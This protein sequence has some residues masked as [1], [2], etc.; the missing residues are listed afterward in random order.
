M[1]V[2]QFVLPPSKT[3]VP[4][5]ARFGAAGICN[6]D[7]VYVSTDMHAAT[8]F[9]CMHPSDNGRVYEV[10]PIGPLTDDPDAKKKDLSFECD[11][12]RI[13]RVIRVSGKT[14]KTVQKY[15]LAEIRR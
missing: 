10:E 4:S 1:K 9:A 5:T 8:Y 7:K 6:V 15:M 14:K 2:G 3:G 12:A 13:V 11:M